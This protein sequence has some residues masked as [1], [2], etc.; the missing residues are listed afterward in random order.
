[1]SFNNNSSLLAY[2]SS[3]GHQKIWDLKTQKTQLNNKLDKSYVTS[4]CFNNDSTIV[5]SSTNTGSLNFNGITNN[6]FYKYDTYEKINIVKYSPFY[7]NNIAFCADDGTVRIYDTKDNQL[8]HNFAYHDR[9]A[10]SIAFSPINKSFLCSVGLDKKINFYDIV[11]KKII[12]PIMTEHQLTCVSFNTDGYNIA[13]GTTG[14]LILIYD[15]RNNSAPKDK[16]TGHMGKVNFVEFSKKSN[17]VSTERKNTN[18]TVDYNKS[19]N[20]VILNPTG[21]ISSTTP[22]LQPN[23]L[24][25]SNNSRNENKGSSQSIDDILGELKQTTFKEKNSIYTI[26]KPETVKPI[27]P[28]KIETSK[29]TIPSEPVKPIEYKKVEMPSDLD[30]KIEDVVNNAIE[31]EV[32]KL[33]VFIHEEFNAL[34]VDLIRQFQIQQVSFF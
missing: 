25:Q 18:T 29:S 5:C 17:K 6:T 4:M 20:S 16:L 30:K 8:I 26:K 23:I 34:H 21:S 12:R 24:N 33:K 9:P 27:E 10:T 28:F 1:M 3:K 22:V 31:K 15:L 19:N 11:D 2:A 7:V 13:V 32:N 14:G